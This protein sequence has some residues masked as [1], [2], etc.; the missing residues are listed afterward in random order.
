[1]SSRSFH[2][3]KS[4]S[5]TTAAKNDCTTLN[6]HCVTFTSILFGNSLS[7]AAYMDGVYMADTDI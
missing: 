3:E 7:T 4:L 6:K 2:I 1:M 5:A